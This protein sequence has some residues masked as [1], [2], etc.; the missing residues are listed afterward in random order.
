MFSV[1]RR[2]SVFSSTSRLKSWR[3]RWTVSEPIATANPH[4]ITNVS[5]AETPA[6]RTL[7]GRRS[8]GTGHARRE[9]PRRRE[10]FRPGGRSRLP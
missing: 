1:V 2:R 4:R 10:A 6:R 7:I 8:E 5:A 9:P 3:M